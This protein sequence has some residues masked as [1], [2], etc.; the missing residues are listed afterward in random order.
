MKTGRDSLTQ[1]EKYSAK[2]LQSVAL[3]MFP[4]AD[5]CVR[6]GKKRLRLLLALSC[7]RSSGTGRRGLRPGLA[8]FYSLKGQKR[9]RASRGSALLPLVAGQGTDQNHDNERQEQASN[10]AQHALRMGEQQQQ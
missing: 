3:K 9:V 10:P 4:H 5:S 2:L 6:S 8:C 1:L 7:G